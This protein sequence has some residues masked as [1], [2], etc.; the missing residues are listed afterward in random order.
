MFFNVQAR[1]SGVV[2]SVVL[3]RPPNDNDGNA[4]GNDNNGDGND[5]GSLSRSVRRATRFVNT[6]LPRRGSSSSS[7]GR[8]RSE[9]LGRSNSLASVISCMLLESDTV[10]L[11]KFKLDQVAN[12]PDTYHQLTLLTLIPFF[13]L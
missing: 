2:L 7:G 13:K 4:D 6:V 11:D 3:N 10:S 12:N 5:D 1:D 9:G 8:M